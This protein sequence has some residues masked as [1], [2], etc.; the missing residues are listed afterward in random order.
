MP[1][2]LHFYVNSCVFK[3]SEFV[4]VFVCVLPSS[5]KIYNNLYY[6][7]YSVALCHC[8]RA[9]R[10]SMDTT[11]I[12]NLWCCVEP[13]ACSLIVVCGNFGMFV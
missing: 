5:V 10:M 8:A 11:Q 6:L 7:L 13:W 9:S 2:G 3:E 1:R 12:V 4:S